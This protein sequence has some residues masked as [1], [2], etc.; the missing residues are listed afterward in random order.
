MDSKAVLAFVRQLCDDIDES[1]PIRYGLRRVVLPLAVPAV[2]GLGIGAAACGASTPLRGNEVC[3]NG[4]DDDGN[5]LVDCDDSACDSDAGC[6]AAVPGCEPRREYCEDDVDND[7]NGST[8]CDD[9]CCAA[10]CFARDCPGCRY[11][12]VFIP[13][14]HEEDCGDGQDLDCDGLT[15][16]CDPDCAGDPL[17]QE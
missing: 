2:L 11:A 13:F 15:D 16:C 9:P 1:R 14:E 8:D 7:G 6:L 5:G 12:A 17:C 3:D 10:F 4:L